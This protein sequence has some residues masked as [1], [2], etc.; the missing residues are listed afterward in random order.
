MGLAAP[1]QAWHLEFKREIKAC[2]P[3][4]EGET[5][6][7]R[8]ITH[9][10]A[11]ALPCAPFSLE[12]GEGPGRAGRRLCPRSW[13]GSSRLTRREVRPSVLAGSFV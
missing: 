10:V 13:S 3:L 6:A 7:R 9:L 8:E 4:S 5:E 2:R 11:R 12:L 1:G